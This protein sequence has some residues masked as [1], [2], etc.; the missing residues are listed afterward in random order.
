MIM[1]GVNL[2]IKSCLHVGMVALV[3][4]ETVHLI[5]RQDL[6]IEATLITTV[7]TRRTAGTS[8]AKMGAVRRNHAHLYTEQCLCVHEYRYA[9][10][11]IVNSIIEHQ[12]IF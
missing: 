7:K 12:M 4:K 8:I 2:S 11:T 10:V 6:R 3:T 1:K 9:Q 5:I